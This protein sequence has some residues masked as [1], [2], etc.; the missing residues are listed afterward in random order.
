MEVAINREMSLFV[1]TLIGL[2]LLLAGSFEPEVLQ[3]GL[4]PENVLLVV[5]EKM[6]HH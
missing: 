1:R 6:R 5:N 4:G 2:V 3:A